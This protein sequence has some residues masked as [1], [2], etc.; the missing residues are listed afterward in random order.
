MSLHT[1]P[2]VLFAGGKSSRMGKDKALLPFAGKESLAKY[3]YERLEE[4][5]ERVY[6]STKD[7]NKFDH[8]DAVIIEDD[9]GKDVYAPTAGFANVFKRL[10]KDNLI[11]VMSVDTP[12]VHKGIIDKFIAV[13]DKNYDAI[14]IRTPSGIHPLCGIYSRSLEKPL[15]KM[16]HE[17]EHKL[18]KLLQNSSVFYL[19]IEDEDALLNMN[20][21]DD[22]EKALRIQDEHLI[23]LLSL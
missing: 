1:I 3:Q 15:L 2:C 16:L 19:D 18:T 22:Y 21:P 6:L 20:T 7:A 23:S 4:I 10:K 13:V 12:F 5:F 14:I 8:F 11:F 17:G 9:L